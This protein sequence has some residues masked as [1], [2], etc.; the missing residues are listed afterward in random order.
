MNI[1]EF[2]ELYDSGERDFTHVNLDTARIYECNIENVDFSYTELSDFYSSQASFINCNFTNANLAN[3]EMREGGLVNCNL[4]NAN[5]SGAKISE[6]DHCFF[7]DTIM[8]D[9]SYNSDG[10]V[11]FRQDG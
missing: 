7:K 11:L 1:E 10:I 4:T 8:S 5:L 6:I 9:G 2:L 3:M